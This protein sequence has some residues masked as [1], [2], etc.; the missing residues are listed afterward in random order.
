MLEHLG[1]DMDRGVITVPGVFG[2]NPDGAFNFK[3]AL[4]PQEIRYLLL[5]WDKILIPDNN[6]ISMGIPEQDVLIECGSIKRPFVRFNI[7]GMM[8]GD[9]ITQSLLSC[10]SIVSDSVSNDDTTDWVVH[11][12]GEKLYT[13][14]HNRVDTTL[15]R[16]D[17]LNSLPVPGADVPI[18]DLLDFKA[19]RSDEFNELHFKLD[20]FY[21]E[22][23]ANPDPKSY[24]KIQSEL[25]DIIKVISDVSGEQ[26][27]I[28]NKFNLSI[29][30]NLSGKDIS[31]GAAG[32]TIA[33]Q[34]IIDAF[35][36]P[37]GIPL[38]TIVGGLSSM[39]KI[40]VKNDT[41]IERTSSKEK[42]AYLSNASKENII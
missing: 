19:R 10:Q 17:L 26:F 1:A 6:L 16:V 29:Q 9:M 22:I 2:T 21:Q 7:N 33:G 5:Y 28:K 15:L 12:Q 8:T 20:E 35:T 38:G 41:T 23:L 13:D 25:S 36:I 30:L 39:V 24:E 4:S 37:V 3:R 31:V 14:P 18:Y 32:G 40:Q 11:Q 27:D 42:L 34:A